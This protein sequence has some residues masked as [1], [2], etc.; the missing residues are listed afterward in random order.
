M[1]TRKSKTMHPQHNTLLQLLAAQTENDGWLPTSA[2]PLTDVDYQHR[3]TAQQNHWVIARGSM[4][5]REFRITQLGKILIGMETAKPTLSVKEK[6]LIIAKSQM[7]VRMKKA[8][9]AR[10]QQGT[11]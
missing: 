2:I 6:A 10:L 7:R 3:K 1:A 4:R 5:H 9:A 8:A 11:E